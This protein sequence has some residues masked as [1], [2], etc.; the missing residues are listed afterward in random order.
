M[1]DYRQMAS[2]L[3][4]ILTQ[5]QDQCFRPTPQTKVL[6]YQHFRVA[7]KHLHSALNELD[8]IAVEDTSENPDS[9]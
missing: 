6:L 8:R 4:N 5:L 7:E 3:A 9:K 2:D 1:P